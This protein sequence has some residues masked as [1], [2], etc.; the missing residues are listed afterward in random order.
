LTRYSLLLDESYDDAANVYVVGGVIIATDLVAELSAAVSQVSRDLVGDER[1]ELKY[2]ESREVK[3]QLASHGTSTSAAR[4]RMALVPGKVEGVVLV[5]SIILDPTSDAT[6]GSLKPL[7]WALLRCVTHFTNFLS[8][9]GASTA[10]GSH[11]IIADRFPGRTHHTAFHDAYRDAFDAVPHGSTPKSMGVLD[12]MTEADATHCAP[13]R[14]ADFFSGTVRA[15][16]HAEHR[17]DANPNPFTG[18]DTSRPRYAL[19]RYM[20][21]IRGNRRS[22]DQKGGYGLAIW[23]EDRRPQLDLWL[24]RTRGRRIEETYEEPH[25]GLRK[26]NDGS[27]ALTFT[28]GTTRSWE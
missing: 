3:S 12:F 4:E 28:P 1:A 19:N 21:F 2:T 23:P 26:R 7:S 13:L 5:A 17:Y 8:D 14:L 10:P 11:L 6:A 20:H 9:A 18:K 16:A 24:A 25:T 27:F 22:P 15:W